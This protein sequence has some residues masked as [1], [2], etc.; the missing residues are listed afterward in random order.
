[1][2]CRSKHYLEY[3][4]DAVLVPVPLHPVR[5][6]ERGFNQSEHIAR[7]LAHCS[8]NTARVEKLLVRSHYTQSQTH[9][10]RAARSQNV[11]NAFALAHDAVLDS[12]NSYIIVDDVFTTGST[13]NACAQTLRK[14]GATR[15]KVATI[16]H[17]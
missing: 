1:M 17:G 13:L 15:L 10:N 3:I 5:L 14:A 11:K 16:G 12:K 8:D 6:R 2:V 7:M 4:R 9:L